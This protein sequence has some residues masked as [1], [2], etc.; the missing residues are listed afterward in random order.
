[1]A[2]ERGKKKNEIVS[3]IF[4]FQ[5]H[6]PPTPSSSTASYVDRN[7][8]QENISGYGSLGT[9][10]SHV[11]LT[12]QTTAS[13]DDHEGLYL[14][15]THQLLRER[16]LVKEGKDSDDDDDDDDSSLS[17][18]EGCEQ[19]HILFYPAT[20]SSGHEPL[21]SYQNSLVSDDSQTEY[22]SHTTQERSKSVYHF[23]SSCFSCF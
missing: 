5:T 21:Y 23:F 1:M 4:F 11:D 20:L 2:I 7:E 13:P 14:L 16:G 19:R 18:D 3:S 15:W 9:T 8:V 10:G 17:G 6:L 22:M 12:R